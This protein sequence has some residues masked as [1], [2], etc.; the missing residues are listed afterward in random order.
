[1]VSCSA[2]ALSLV[3]ATGLGSFTILS[4]FDSQVRHIEFDCW[5]P[6]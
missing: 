1:M 3:G 6:P 2:K 4:D 5:H